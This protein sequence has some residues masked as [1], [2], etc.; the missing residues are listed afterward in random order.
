L[1]ESLGLAEEDVERIVGREER[2]L[3]RRVV[4]YRGER[5]AL[6]VRDKTVIVVDD[7]EIPAGVSLTVAP[8]TVVKLDSYVRIETFGQLRALGTPDAPIVFTSMLDDERGGDS[9]GDAD[10]T[11]PA[12]DDWDW[13]AVEG[14]SATAELAHVEIHYAEMGIA[15]FSQGPKSVSY[16]A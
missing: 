5:E 12:A 7:I 8:G 13:I 2:E 10:A 4:A 11:Q 3:Q 1:L 15:A 9:N 16:P 6:G 14:A